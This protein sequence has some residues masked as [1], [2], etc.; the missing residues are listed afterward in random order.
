MHPICLR[1]P[2]PLIT[3][4]AVAGCGQDFTSD[5]QPEA[6]VEIIGSAPTTLPHTDSSKVTVRVVDA[7]G[8][9]VYGA[10]V[11]WTSSDSSVLSVSTEKVPIGSTAAEST[12]ASLHATIYAHAR[13]SATVSVSVVAG[14]GAALTTSLP[15]L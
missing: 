9:Q 1:I 6:A 15:L 12:E 11:S 7:S 8:D 4:I 13:G 14:T 5:P 10:R 2:S 3:A